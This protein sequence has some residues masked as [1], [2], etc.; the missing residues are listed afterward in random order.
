MSQTVDLAAGVYN[1]SFMAAQRDQSQ[2]RGQTIEILVDGKQ[3]G[4]VYPSAPAS[5]N[6]WYPAGTTFGAYATSNFTV[7]AGV[8]TI[9]FVGLSPSSADSTAFIDDVQLNA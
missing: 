7:T 8:H 5:G 4:L 2:S 3:V 9:V 6:G 1:L